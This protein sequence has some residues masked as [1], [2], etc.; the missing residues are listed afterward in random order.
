MVRLSGQ[1]LFCLI[2]T[3]STMAK[4]SAVAIADP[5]IDSKPALKNAAEV[6]EKDSSNNRESH[7]MKSDVS[8]SNYLKPPNVPAPPKELPTV[9]P[10][11]PAVPASQPIPVPVYS[12]PHET[13][14]GYVY[15]YLPTVE[16]YYPKLKDLMPY[17]KRYEKS[18]M[19][20]V[21]RAWPAMRQMADRTF[22]LTSAIGL[23]ILAPALFV[24]M[25]LF[26]GFVVILFLF[27]AV[28]AFGKRRMGR[29]LNGVEENHDAF[30]FDSLL[31]LEQSR[32]LVTL[33]ARVDNVLENYKRALQSDACLERLSCE[34]GHF[35]SRIGKFAEPMIT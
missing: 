14:M 1:A 8:Y 31:P 23:V 34:A 19:Q 25:I 29:D 2:L 12:N 7:A 28:S 26:L 9:P 33:A 11:L 4:C 5:A 13:T 6:I 32:S 27:P 24:S 3:T 10:S 35:S 15:Y 22:D 30:D 20:H 16:K 21:S 18:A 17:F